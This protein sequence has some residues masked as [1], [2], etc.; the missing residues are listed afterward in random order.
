M[1]E[2]SIV[3]SIVEENKVLSRM[4]EGL[5]GQDDKVRSDL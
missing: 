2:N 4:S 3:D 5:G 1:N